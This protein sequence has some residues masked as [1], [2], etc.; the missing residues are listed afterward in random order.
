MTNEDLPHLGRVD[1]RDDDRMFGIKNE[2]RFS[3]IYIIGKTGTGKASFVGH[4]RQSS[5]ELKH[6]AHRRS[7]PL[8]PSRCTNLV[9]HPG[10]LGPF[11]ASWPQVLKHSSTAYPQIRS[12]WSHPDVVNA[13]HFVSTGLTPV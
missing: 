9:L 10:P 5:I 4:I 13:G 1:F 7:A 2:D 11:V 3:H 8:P 12:Q 6:L